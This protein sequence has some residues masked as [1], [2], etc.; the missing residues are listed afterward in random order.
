MVVSNR[1]CALLGVRGEGDLGLETRAKT[2]G[3]RSIRPIYDGIL[4]FQVTATIFLW[5]ISS[6][7]LTAGGRGAAAGKPAQIANIFAFFLSKK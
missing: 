7:N 6:R 3:N 5:L 1:T 4:D 2:D